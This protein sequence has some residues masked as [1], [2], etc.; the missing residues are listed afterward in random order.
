MKKLLI[1][2]FCLLLTS[3]SAKS[4]IAEIPDHEFTKFEYHR[5]GNVT[6]ADIVAINAVRDENGVAIESV[7]ITADYGPFVNFNVSIEGY[8][9]PVI[10]ENVPEEIQR[11]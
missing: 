10:T 8:Y 1:I 9:R 6:S 5:A 3:C 11:E 2:I 4:L 7:K